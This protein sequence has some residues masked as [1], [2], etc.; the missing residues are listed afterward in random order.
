M[1]TDIHVREAFASHRFD[2]S[3]GL[4]GPMLGGGQPSTSVRAFI[5]V[6]TPR[7]PTIAGCFT[8]EDVYHMKYGIN[9]DPDHPGG[10]PIDLGSYDDVQANAAVILDSVTTD[11][12]NRRMP[13]AWDE[14]DPWPVDLVDLFRQWVTGG[15]PR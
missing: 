3:Q 13:P 14:R 8:P 12:P 4:R 1:P 10:Y 6:R 2:P 15:T 7:W 9:A 11:D 5:A